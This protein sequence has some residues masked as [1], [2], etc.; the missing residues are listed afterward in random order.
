M[1]S[2]DKKT[3]LTNILT[4]I[5]GSSNRIVQSKLTDSYKSA[6]TFRVW[7]QHPKKTLTDSEVK[8]IRNTM[9]KR[10]ERKFGATQKK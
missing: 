3:K 8:H 2:P 6:H 9:L 5:E 4:A 7:F 1:I 10:V